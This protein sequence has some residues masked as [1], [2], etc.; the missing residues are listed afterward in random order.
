MT[1]DEIKK[2]LQ[3]APA[4]FA[5]TLLLTAAATGARH[6]ELL[7]LGWRDVDFEG[8]TVRVRR[9]L[10]WVATDEGSAPR[11]FPP[12]TKAGRRKIP[13]PPPLLQALRRWFLQSHYKAECDLI[14]PNAAGA[15]R[16]HRAVNR[17]VRRLRTRIGLRTFTMYSLRHTFASSLL[18]GGASIAEVQKYMGHKTPAVTLNTY[19]HFL[20]TEDSGAVAAHVARLF[21]YGHFL[22]TLAASGSDQPDSAAVSA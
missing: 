22:D 7:A 12:K 20:P 16:D 6:N 15:P 1:P 2:L 18:Q 21:P 19:T 8:G 17:R 9:T 13:A 14:F 11:Y 3:G 5:Y 10:S 4:G